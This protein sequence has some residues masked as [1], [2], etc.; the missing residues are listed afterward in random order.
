MEQSGVLFRVRIDA[1]IE[2]RFG[3]GWM[4]VC[5]WECGPLD[6]VSWL[7]VCWENSQIHFVKDLLS[8]YVFMNQSSFHVNCLAWIE[9]FGHT[10]IAVWGYSITALTLPVALEKGTA[11]AN[12]HWICAGNIFNL[13][14]LAKYNI[15]F[16]VTY[17]S[18]GQTCQ[19]FI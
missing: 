4:V 1:Q 3:P 18:K 12:S 16:L 6:L 8:K 15:I 19:R 7:T 13:R 11:L 2:S 5:F 17:W 14:F 9:W 10:N